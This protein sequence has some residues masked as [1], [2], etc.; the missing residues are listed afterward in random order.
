MVCS[1]DCNTVTSTEA[2]LTKKAP[3]SITTTPGSQTVKV[4]DSTTF[5]VVAA[6]HNL[7]YQWQVST[8]SGSTW[9]NVTNSS[10]Y[11]GATTTTLSVAN[12][13]LAMNGYQYQLLISQSNYICGNITSN[14][15][16]LTFLGLIA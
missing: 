14:A 1:G 9:T 7:R 5:T 16:T 6:G 2:T 13:A 8:N 15:A 4:G 11:S 12:A 10:T 3:T